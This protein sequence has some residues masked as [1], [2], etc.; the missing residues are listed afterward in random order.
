MPWNGDVM[1]DPMDEAK[2]EAVAKAAVDRFSKL[3]ETLGGTASA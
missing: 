1:T 2:L 3:I